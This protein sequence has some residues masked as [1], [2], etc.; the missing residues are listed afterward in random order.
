MFERESSGKYAPSP[1][2]CTLPGT[3]KLGGLYLVPTLA[4]AYLRRRPKSVLF[5]STSSSCGQGHHGGGRSR[6]PQE[7]TSRGRLSVWTLALSREALQQVI[8]RH[9]EPQ[10]EGPGTPQP[11]PSGPG[12]LFRPGGSSLKSLRAGMGPGH[13]SCAV[14]GKKISRHRCTVSCGETTLWPTVRGS[15]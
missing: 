3:G 10:E 4:Q 7:P 5:T 13:A 6:S 9:P 15:A 14:S 2:R 12:A 11:P 1:V 8:G